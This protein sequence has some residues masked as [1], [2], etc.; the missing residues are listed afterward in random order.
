MGRRYICGCHV[1]FEDHISFCAIHEN[2]HFVLDTLKWVAQSSHDT[3]HDPH[4]PFVECTHATCHS[5]KKAFARV[6][7]HETYEYK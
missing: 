3:Y 1:R 7:P 4:V 5:A 2:G 6:A